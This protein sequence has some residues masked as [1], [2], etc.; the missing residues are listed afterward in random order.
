MQSQRGSEKIRVSIDMLLSRKQ[1]LYFIERDALYV[2]M[3]L[4]SYPGHR[5]KLYIST[6]LQ[7]E[8]G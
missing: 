8:S 7:T 4:Q 1:H 6:L 2:T 3:S 5:T